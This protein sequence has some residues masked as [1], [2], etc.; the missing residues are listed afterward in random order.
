MQMAI[1]DIRER[2][3]ANMLKLNDNTTEKLVIG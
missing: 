1:N 2:H 3:V